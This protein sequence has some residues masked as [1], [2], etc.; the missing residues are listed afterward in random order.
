MSS[1]ITARQI[2]SNE[3]WRTLWKKSLRA[4]SRVMKRIMMGMR[5]EIAISTEAVRL[6][7]RMRA[8]WYL[9]RNLTGGSAQRFLSSPDQST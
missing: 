6:G 3:S 5:K 2:S 8:G 7:G 4:E 1:W 9:R